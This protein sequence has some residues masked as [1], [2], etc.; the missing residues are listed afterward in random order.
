MKVKRGKVCDLSQGGEIEL[1]IQ[2]FVN[3]GKHPVHAM[4]VL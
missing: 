4:F 3:V 2:M 1:L